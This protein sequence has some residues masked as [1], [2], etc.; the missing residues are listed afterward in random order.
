MSLVGEVEMQRNRLRHS[1]DL[2]GRLNVGPLESGRIQLT[3]SISSLSICR[4][5]G[6]SLSRHRDE[7]V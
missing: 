2:I 7:T 4:V 6:E 1:E 5:K 3:P